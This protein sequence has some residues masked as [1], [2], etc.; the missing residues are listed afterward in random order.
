MSIGRITS[1]YPAGYEAKRTARN[2]SGKGFD[3]AALG[4]T[5][6][7]KKFADT[8]R[9]TSALDIYNSMSKFGGNVSKIVET[10]SMLP[11]SH[12]IAGAAEDAVREMQMSEEEL[13]QTAEQE[14]ETKTEIIVNPD[15][16]RVLVMT[17]SVGG[18]ETTM[19]LEISKPTKAPNE[20]SKQAAD[21]NISTVDTEMNTVSDEMP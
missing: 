20:Y 10:K 21:N 19:S 13:K 5:D 6:Y 3:N 15:G 16:S 4:E 11:Q 14:S 18:M 17:T 2:S 1:N 9:Q 7:I 12:V 8:T